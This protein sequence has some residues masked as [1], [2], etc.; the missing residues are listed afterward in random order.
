VAAW[1][2]TAIDGWQ[3]QRLAESGA[4]SW[5]QFWEA[6]RA[7]PVFAPLLD[8][9]DRR[10]ASRQRARALPFDFH[11]EALRTVG[12]QEVADVWRLHDDSVLLAIR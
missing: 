12:F 9:R 11:H 2:R 4:E 1:G 5:E 3:A 8:E 10:F 6:A 7:E